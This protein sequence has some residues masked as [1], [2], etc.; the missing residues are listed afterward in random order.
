MKRW[1]VVAVALLSIGG[2]ADAQYRWRDA[3]GQVNYGDFPPGDARDLKPRRS[4]RSDRNRGRQPRT[5]LRTAAC[6]GAVSGR[7][8]LE[9]R[10]PALRERAASSCASVAC[11]FPSASWKLRTMAWN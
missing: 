7:A 10:L 9:R 4:A 2:T 6:E 8:V 5:A 1:W 11:H 3:T